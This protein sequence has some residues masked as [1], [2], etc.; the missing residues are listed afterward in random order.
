MAMHES[1]FGMS[2]LSQERN[3][4]FGIK[5]YDSNLDG[6]ET[7]VDP[8]ESIDGLAT[9]YLNLNYINPLW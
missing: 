7:F 6:A 3:N 1:D 4:L 5:A 9:R 2:P 8:S